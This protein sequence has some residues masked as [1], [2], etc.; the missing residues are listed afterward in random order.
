MGGDWKN[1]L[2]TKRYDLNLELSSDKL[3]LAEIFFAPNLTQNYPSHLKL[4][5]EQQCELWIKN[6]Q[7]MIDND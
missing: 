7:V 6:M 5:D 3:M 1:L 2:V 4:M